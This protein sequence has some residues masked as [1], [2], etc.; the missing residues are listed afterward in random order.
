MSTLADTSKWIET[1]S[2][3]RRL[4]R[5]LRGAAVML[6]VLGSLQ[7]VAGVLAAL[8]GSNDAV[9]L[10]GAVVGLSAIAPVMLAYAFDWMR[11]MVIVIDA[12][13]YEVFQRN[14]QTGQE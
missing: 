8:A 9:R 12:Q 6:R 1:V 3:H 7:A 14:A 13:T 10:L 4:R 5:A 11:A 2:P